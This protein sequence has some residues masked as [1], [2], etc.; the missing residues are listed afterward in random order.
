MAGDVAT[1][2]Y[3]SYATKNEQ[4]L[5]QDCSDYGMGGCVNC[6]KRGRGR[7]PEL[8]SWAGSFMVIEKEVVPPGWRISNTGG[9]RHLNRQ[10]G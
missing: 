4:H 7:A 5:E 1:L 3:L 6:R 8:S 10:E 9:A 2:G